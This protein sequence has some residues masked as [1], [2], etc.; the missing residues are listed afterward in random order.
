MENLRDL[1]GEYYHSNSSFDQTLSHSVLTVE[2]DIRLYR[3]GGVDL[4]EEILKM[5]Q[6]T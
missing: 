1:A 6:L 5:E 2:L 4:F 3:S